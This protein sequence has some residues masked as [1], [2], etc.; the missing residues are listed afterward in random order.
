MTF[1]TFTSSYTAL[2]SLKTARLTSW[3][4]YFIRF[5]LYMQAAW[6]SWAC[7]TRTYFYVSIKKQQ[8]LTCWECSSLTQRSQRSTQSFFCY[9]KTC[10]CKGSS[11]WL[12]K[13]SLRALVD[14]LSRVSEL[15]ISPMFLSRASC[16]I[17]AI[18]P[19]RVLK[20]WPA[21]LFSQCVALRLSTRLCF[22][23]SDPF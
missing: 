19:R 6:T 11:K 7:C 21:A 15:P 14:F 5:T 1:T 4:R 17:L 12:L 22:L 8:L 23:D 3:S 2:I 10:F 18:Y 16:K 13:S 20:R 9:S